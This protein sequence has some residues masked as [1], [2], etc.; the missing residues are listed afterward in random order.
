MS[1]VKNGPKFKLATANVILIANAFVWYLLAFNT[2]K[3]LLGLEPTTPQSLLVFGINTG[4]IAIAGLIGSLLIDKIKNRVRF[5]YLWIASGII[6]SLIPLALNVSDIN[7]LCIVSLVFGLYFGF[8]MPATM[9]YHSSLMNIEGRAKV[10]G[11][12]FLIIGGTFAFAGLLIFNSLIV[13]CLVLALV[14]LL[15]LAVFHFFRTKEEPHKETVKM[16]YRQILS[17]KSFLLYFAPWCMFTLV[18][19]MTIPLQLQIF[20][21]QQN[22]ET[23]TSWENAVIAIVAVVSGFIADKLGRK[24]LIIIGFIMLGIGYAFVGLFAIN[25]ADKLLGS[26]IYIISDGIAWGIFYVLFVFTLWGDLSPKSKQRQTI[27]PWRIAICV[28]VFYATIICAVH[29]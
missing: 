17:N 5:L 15:G 14:R 28:L 7:Q 9:G 12:A 27:F 11:F 23:L 21:T 8:G 26:L 22:Y 6:L 2:L 10:G 4:A 29:S 19:Y 24:R 16:T 25:S 13:T 1:S 3:S 20:G 18:N